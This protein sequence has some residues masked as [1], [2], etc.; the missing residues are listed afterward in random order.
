MLFR[1]C[2]ESITSSPR[3]SPFQGLCSVANGAV[4]DHT[5]EPRGCIDPHLLSYLLHLMSRKISDLH[6]ISLHFSGV[7]LLYSSLVTPALTDHC[8][9]ASVTLSAMGLPYCNVQ[10]W[11]RPPPVFFLTAQ[12]LRMSLFLNGWKISKEL[13]SLTTCENDMQFKFRCP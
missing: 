11:F 1:V 3:P 10:V 7:R 8:P 4:I 6:K 9:A 2:S 5:E 12:E 13:S